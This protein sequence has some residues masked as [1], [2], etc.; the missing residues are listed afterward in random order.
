MLLRLVFSPP[1]PSVFA[2]TD[3][4]EDL[5]NCNDL[6]QEAKLHFSF[7]FKQLARIVKP[8]RVVIVHCQQISGLVRN[9]EVGTYDFRGLLI[10]LAQ[11]AGLIYQYDWLVGKNPQSA[12]IRTHSRKLLFVTLERD[13]SVSCGVAG[14]YLIKFI[15]PGENQVPINSPD[16]ISRQNWIEWAECHWPCTDIRET[17]TLNTKEAK[18]EN[19]TK[20]ICPLQLPVIRRLI[21]LYTN[22]NEVVF[23]PFAGIGSEG[24]CALQL[25]RMFWGCE[26]KDEYVDA[27]RRNLAK[28]ENMHGEQMALFPEE[29]NA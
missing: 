7:F 15:M 10:R 2:Y 26:I 27:A 16:E 9:G 6:Q 23:S 24:Y 14:D 5:G 18:G 1:F 3:K 17:D 21:K 4:P 20:H 13:R 25:G 12:A 29:S 8:G 28:A 11:R 19:D 22:P